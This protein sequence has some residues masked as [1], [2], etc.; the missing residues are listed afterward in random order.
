MKTVIPYQEN[1]DLKKK[2]DYEKEMPYFASKFVIYE[3]Y[4]FVIGEED[5]YGNRELYIQVINENKKYFDPSTYTGH[6][7]L[8]IAKLPLDKEIVNIKDFKKGKET[9]NQ[10]ESYSI[11]SPKNKAALI[12]FCKNYGLLGV[13]DR[14]YSHIQISEND[15]IKGS[16]NLHVL[17]VKKDILN[18]E[19]IDEIYRMKIVSNY[20]QKRYDGTITSK[21]REDLMNIANSEQSY[22]HRRLQ[23]QGEDYYP[24]L[25]FS[26]LIDFAWWQLYES[27]TRGVR[28]DTCKNDKC[29][30]VFAVTHGNQEYCPPYPTQEISP[31]Q[32]AAKKRRQYR[33]K[34][35]LKLRE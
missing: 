14:K 24:S 3:D 32:N 22:I 31:C 13:T 9:T 21:E 29:G 35:L 15:F 33:K 26:S 20:L 4:E 27:L 10:V 30:K 18:K 16:E 25:L 34:K 1:R 11:S 28:Y 2:A 7:Y 17:D 23:L 6:L 19:L 12:K 5:I 8:E